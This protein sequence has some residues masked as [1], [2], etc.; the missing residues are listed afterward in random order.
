MTT[1]IVT[2]TRRHGSQIGNPT[3]GGQPAPPTGR[4]SVT[5]G[6]R[7]PDLEARQKARD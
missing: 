3:S 5:N 1:P 6:R 2:E 4:T 7:G